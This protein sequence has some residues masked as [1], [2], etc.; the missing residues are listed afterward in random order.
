MIYSKG[1]VFP[2]KRLLGRQTHWFYT[3]KPM[4]VLAN[5]PTYFQT[6]KK[7]RLTCFVRRSEPKIMIQTL[8]RWSEK[9]SRTEVYGVR[10]SAKLAWTVKTLNCST[11]TTVVTKWSL[12]SRAAPVKS[13]NLVL[14]ALW[15]RLHVPR[16]FLGH[17]V[18]F[19][20][21][22]LFWL[23]LSSKHH[24]ALETSNA[25]VTQHCSSLFTS[26]FKPVHT[27]K[28]SVASFYQTHKSQKKLF[29]Q[30]CPIE[31]LPTI[32][33]EGFSASGEGLPFWE[34]SF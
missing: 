5:W 7:G 17:F 27:R 14:T 34:L 9:E 20:Q 12:F 8:H 33:T 13:L 22:T 32:W 11:V 4:A 6:L 21:G 19:R 16:Q 15:A 1:R 23:F 30:N 26:C 24:K 10:T 28:C 18:K 25:S 31:R 3:N 2:T 29:S